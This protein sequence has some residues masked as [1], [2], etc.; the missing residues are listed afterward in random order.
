MKL[1]GL[2][3]CRLDLFGLYWC[4]WGV[5]VMWDRR[6]VEKIDEAVG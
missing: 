2:P 1:V 4:F 5:L 6:T 3:A